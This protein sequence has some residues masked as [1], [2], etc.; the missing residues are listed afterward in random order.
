M[1]NKPSGGPI[2]NGASLVFYGSVFVNW[3][4]SA[5][6]SQLNNLALSNPKSYFIFKATAL[7]WGN[8]LL[9]DVAVRTEYHTMVYYESQRILDSVTRGELTPF[10]AAEQ[11][12]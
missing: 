8:W 11:A 1:G 7:F 2:R 4:L 12:A 5:L 3:D 9:T 10:K 6:F